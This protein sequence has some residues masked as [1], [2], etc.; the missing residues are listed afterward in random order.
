MQ[1]TI[2]FYIYLMN[3]PNMFHKNDLDRFSHDDVDADND[4]D[5]SVGPIITAISA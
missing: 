1:S 4:D 5:D 2:P 3:K